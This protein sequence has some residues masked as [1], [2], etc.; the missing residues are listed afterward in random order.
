MLIRRYPSAGFL[1]CDELYKSRGHNPR[2]L[3]RQ[4]VCLWYLLQQADGS[5][6]LS[7]KEAIKELRRLVGSDIKPKKAIELARR[8]KLINVKTLAGQKWLA[9]KDDA[10]NERLIF[11]YTTKLRDA[12]ANTHRKPRESSDLDSE[13]EV[14]PADGGR[15]NR[16]DNITR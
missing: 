16:K 13:F 6:W 12:S 8:A 10:I 1:R 3:K 4:A 5:T 11:N 7:V 15:R 2:R 9:M 14:L